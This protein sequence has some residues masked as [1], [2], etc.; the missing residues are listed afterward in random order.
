MEKFI[1]WLSFCEWLLPL[2]ITELTKII[3]AMLWVSPASFFLLGIH[4]IQL[5]IEYHDAINFDYV[6]SYC[7]GFIKTLK[8]I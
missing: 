1:L 8:Y 7:E 5:P 2:K 3:W 4:S 6:E